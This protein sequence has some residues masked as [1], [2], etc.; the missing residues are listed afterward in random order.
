M[1]MHA[2]RQ[3]GPH[4]WLLCGKTRPGTRLGADIRGYLRNDSACLLGTGSIVRHLTRA[5]YTTA[6]LGSTC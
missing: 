2:I 5:E 6:S 3:F 4:P 1:E